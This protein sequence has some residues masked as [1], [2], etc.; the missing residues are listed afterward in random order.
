MNV[1]SNEM[2]ETYFFKSI[3]ALIPWTGFAA[4]LLSLIHFLN[5]LVGF[6]GL[7]VW[8]LTGIY[9]MQQ[10]KETLEQ[11]RIKTQMDLLELKHQQDKESRHNK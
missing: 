7:L 2:N 5:P 10:A 6:I 3:L 11:K 4:F 8:L 1:E 9:K